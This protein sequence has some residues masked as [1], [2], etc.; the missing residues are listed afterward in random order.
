MTMTRNTTTAAEAA[1]M[2][3]AKESLSAAATESPALTSGF[4]A[5]FASPIYKGMFDFELSEC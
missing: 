1:P 3:A 4:E 5:Y 2:S